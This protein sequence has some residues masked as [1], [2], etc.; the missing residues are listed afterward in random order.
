[1]KEEN[2]NHRGKYHCTASVLF[3]WFGFDQTSFLFTKA[4]QLNS[5]KINSSAVQSIE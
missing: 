5:N 2:H 3:D 1:M 4:I